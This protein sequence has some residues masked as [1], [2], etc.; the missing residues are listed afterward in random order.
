MF[1]RQALRVA[2]VGA[3]PVGLAT[4][5]LAARQWPAVAAI[6][7]FDA[8][9]EDAPLQQ[10]RRTLALSLG[11]VQT[12]QRLKVWPG[13]GAGDDSA[14]LPG[15][16]AIERIHVS[17]T[18][19]AVLGPAQAAVRLSAQQLGVPLLGAVLGYGALLAPLQA[20][21]LAAV[22]AQP[23]GVERLQARFGRAVQGLK[24]LADGRIELDVG[25]AE[26][27]DLI[28]LAEGGLFDEQ[29]V[30]PIRA[31]YRQTAW[32]GSAVFEGGEAG[33]AN[34]L[35]FERFTRQGP[36]ALL[37]LPSG[38]GLA[39]GQRRMAVVWCVDAADDPVQPLDDTQRL[40]LLATLLP[41]EA[42]RAVTLSPL[43]GFAL[44]LN[45]QSPLQR[46]AGRIVRIG[47]AAQTL[48]PVAGQGLNLGLRDAETL[49]HTLAA[50]Q[51]LDRALARVAWARAPDRL[52][53]VAATDFL[54]RAFT[55][56]APGAGALRAA[57]LAA[58][59]ALPGAKAALARRMMFGWR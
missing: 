15:A 18:P 28:V 17:Q 39:P 42:G 36:L 16:A 50:T 40:A 25:I 52:G 22:R 23:P 24:P 41:P 56:Q 7:V 33:A 38:P 26:A 5:L 21:W 54:A 31:D 48:H 9:A 14:L 13:E 19:G 2:V 8:R 12:L 45:A 4:A 51:D 57:G 6:A 47:N 32:V 3:G 20:A 10:D 1:E 11:S 46:S 30:R 34:T 49:V 59:D 53:L 29:S 27:F 43:K 35:A 58:L 55:W 37:P 44:G